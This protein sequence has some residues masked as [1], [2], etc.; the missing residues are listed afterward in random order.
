M[1]ALYTVVLVLVVSACASIQPSAVQAGDR[2]V[3]C[4]RPIG[5]LRLAAEM[6]DQLKAPYPFRTA[7]CLAKYVKAHPAEKLAA[8]FVTDYRTGKMLP[9][10]S[11]WFVPAAI[12]QVDGKK[13]E[14]DYFA[15]R[16]RSDAEALPG[17]RKVLL[18]WAQV[19]AEAP[20]N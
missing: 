2:C 12:P 18:R 19:V 10:D 1:K 9:A 3:R 8:V 15:F 17:E 20:A 5:D 16:S 11:A 7:G 13:A 4:R 6:F 14:N